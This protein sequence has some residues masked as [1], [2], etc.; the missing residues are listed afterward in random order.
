ML[1]CFFSN[2]GVNAIKDELIG[3]SFDAH[4][5]IIIG[6]IAIFPASL[7]YS[8]NRKIFKFPFIILGIIFGFANFLILE[9]Y[10]NTL[11]VLD[12]V[13][14]SIPIKDIIFISKVS[15]S[16]NIYFLLIAYLL[17]S[18]LIL[19][20]SLRIVKNLSYNK[21][22][23]HFLL[24]TVL[25][26]LIFAKYSQPTNPISK[27]KMLYFIESTF[28]YFT[29]DKYNIS[30]KNELHVLINRYHNFHSNQY[31]INPKYPFYRT[32]STKNVLGSFFNLKQTKPNIVIIIVESLGKA[33]SGNNASIG[34]FTPFLDSL[35]Q[36]SLS[37][38][39]FVVNSERTFGILPGILGSLPYG[40][41]C[42]LKLGNSIP[43]HTTLM[44]ILKN[45]GYYSNFFYGGYPEYDNMNIFLKRN[46]IDYIY[47]EFRFSKNARNY[48]SWGFGDKFLF[49]RSI[50]IKEDHEHSPFLDVYLTLSIHNPWKLDEDSIY[51]L[52]AIDRIK[53]LKKQNKFNNDLLLDQKIL[54]CVL[55]TDD[56]LKDYFDRISKKDYFNNTIFIIT[57]DHRSE[58]I[59]PKSEIDVY[60]V[61]LI[62][63]SSMIKEPAKFKGVSTTQDVTP[64]LIELIKEHLS[65]KI[66][67]T[68]WLGNE[69]DTSKLFSSDKIHPFIKTNKRIEQLIY[70]KYLLSFHKLFELSDG[71][72]TKQIKND[73][74]INLME[75]YLNVYK[76][77]DYYTT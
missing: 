51:K 58:Y 75:D 43:I 35:E 31:F 53:E 5:A 37:W 60:H 19:I 18:I 47:D 26:A 23:I 2:Y 40:R 59:V 6:S 39:N 30:D 42:F 64:T 65:N 48:E 69:L 57:G 46:N 10:R 32:N 61:P 49:K 52:K 7:I 45:E 63:Y 67:K 70:G 54:P 76:K 29:N 27:N 15:A 11:I 12:E 44:S 41:E 20:L 16:L 3:F 34:S 56:A 36:H 66:S 50:E 22:N 74:I 28:T 33:I 17:I 9:Y 62:I 77:L 21:K 73:S 25:I 8:F 38:D 55:Y 72:F 14:F 1:I 71:L 4:L 68:H 13:I 24:G